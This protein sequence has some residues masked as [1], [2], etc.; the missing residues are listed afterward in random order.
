MIQLGTLALVYTYC[1]S[2][3]GKVGKAEHLLNSY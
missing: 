2:D 3:A 1:V